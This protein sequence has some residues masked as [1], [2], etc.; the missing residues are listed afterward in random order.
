[1]YRNYA[2]GIAMNL[3]CQKKYTADS[4]IKLF[5]WYNRYI[6]KHLRENMRYRMAYS[7]CCSATE[8]KEIEDWCKKQ[9]IKCGE[10]GE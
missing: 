10:I 5:R 3:D 6:E 9:G 4:R 1:V 8:I 7:W 2:I